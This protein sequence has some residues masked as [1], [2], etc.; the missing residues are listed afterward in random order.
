MCPLAGCGYDDARGD[1]CDKCGHLLDA[2]DLINP[3]SKF[4]GCTPIIK[5]SKHL[6]I[7][8]AKLM[9]EIEGQYRSVCADW[10][11]NAQQ[12]TEGWF[13][14]GLEPRCI[15]RDLK[16]GVPVPKAGYESKVFYVWFDAPIGYPSITAAY[17]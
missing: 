11:K 1:Q 4:S 9:P 17:T 13:K 10:S 12:I 14:K 2:I 5:T 8:L 15:T 16:W 3:R 7:D 6:Y